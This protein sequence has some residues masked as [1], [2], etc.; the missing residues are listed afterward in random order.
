MRLAEIGL[1]DE[2]DPFSADDLPTRSSGV[3]CPALDSRAIP[4]AAAWPGEPAAAGDAETREEDE[5]E[6]VDEADVLDELSITMDEE[7]SGSLATMLSSPSSRTLAGDSGSFAAAEE[8]RR[9]SGDDGYHLA[10]LVAGMLDDS[11][12]PGRDLG[13][14]PPRSRPAFLG[15]DPLSEAGTA[16]T[17]R[18]DVALSPLDE[19][20]E[21]LTTATGPGLAT[22]DSAEPFADQPTEV[23]DFSRERPRDADDLAVLAGLP[24][25]PTLPPEMQNAN[26]VVLGRPLPP[27]PGQRGPA[28]LTTTGQL[29]AARPGNGPLIPTGGATASGSG[30]GD[31]VSASGSGPSWASR[32]PSSLAVLPSAI[33]DSLIGTVVNDQYRVLRRIGVGGMGAVYLAE[34][35]DVARLVA[36]KV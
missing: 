13:A 27:V 19:A 3:A 35:L 22:Q 10:D 36:L 24:M 28:R 26:T 31:W 21:A 16:P 4:R 5:A 34:Q 18:P 8:P 23:I 29:T 33:D 25:V 14:A 1:D 15:R 30:S 12:G 6:P 2:E 7:G 11:A 20:D 32:S 17:A 9:P